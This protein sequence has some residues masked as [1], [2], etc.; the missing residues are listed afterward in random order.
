M[1]VNLRM[2]L[3]D[4]AAELNLKESY[5]RSHWALV[6][7]RYES[8]GI[9][10]RKRGRGKTADFGVKGYNDTEVRWEHIEGSIF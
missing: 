5:L 8:Y 9:A 2:T 1:E 6:V 7:R 3:S 10:L 4:L